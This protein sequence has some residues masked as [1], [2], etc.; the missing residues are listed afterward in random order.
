[1]VFQHLRNWTRDF[2]TLSIY[3]RFLLDGL[4]IRIKVEGRENRHQF[5]ISP[6]RSTK[7]TKKQHTSSTPP[8]P[9]LAALFFFFSSSSNIFCAN[10]GSTTAL[11]LVETGLAAALGA[12]VGTTTV[13]GSVEGAAVLGARGFFSPRGLSRAANDCFRI[14]KRVGGGK[15][16]LSF[17][18][19]FV[20]PFQKKVVQT[21]TGRIRTSKEHVQ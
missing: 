14:V 5:T 21:K 13:F 11:S 9:N 10:K 17:L 19:T 3:F 18:I 6:T 7:E 2:S 15:S 1:M 20:A 4:F 8:P 16:Q 12:G